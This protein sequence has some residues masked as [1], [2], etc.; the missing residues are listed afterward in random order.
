MP[1]L[2]ELRALLAEGK[3][4]DGTK[5]VAMNVGVDVGGG[6]SKTYKST[7]ERVEGKGILDVESPEETLEDMKEGL[8]PSRFKKLL[9]EKG[10]RKAKA[11]TLEEAL[12]M[13]EAAPVK[14]TKDARYTIST[15]GKDATLHFGK[16]RGSRISDLVKREDT[17]GYLRWLIS[18]A[19]SF[20][21]DL[22]DVTRRI[23]GV[24]PKAPSKPIDWE[25]AEAFPG[26]PE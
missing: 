20:P 16:H 8:R 6:S 26:D 22:V 1:S 14:K 3:A 7:W 2:E 11:S 4:I 9:A 23:L 13:I 19:N 12:E 18:P 21:E 15:D 5:I 24:K 17:K 25:D 10:L